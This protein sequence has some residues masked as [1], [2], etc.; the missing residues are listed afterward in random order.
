MYFNI[1][2]SVFNYFSV[3]SYSYKI[4]LVSLIPYSMHFHPFLN[5]PWVLSIFYSVCI[6]YL[7]YLLKINW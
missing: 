1:P 6:Q 4:S 5:T 7:Q 2:L 3:L